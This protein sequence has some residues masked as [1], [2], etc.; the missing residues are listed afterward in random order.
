MMFR[1]GVLLTL[2]STLALAQD[3]PLVSFGVKGGA[4]IKGLFQDGYTSVFRSSSGDVLRN[5]ANA[6]DKVYLVGPSVEVRLPFRLA[7]EFDALY[8]R[9]NG[10]Q[11]NTTVGS[12]GQFTT[13]GTVTAQQT[14]NRWEFPL[15]AKFRIPAGHHV[16]PFVGVG[17]NFSILSQ[18]RYKSA[19]VFSGQPVSQTSFPQD[20]R[21]FGTGVTASGGLSFDFAHVRFT[22]EVRYTWRDRRFFT[23]PTDQNVVQ[24]LIGISFGK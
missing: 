21:D 12:G 22:P 24:A 14:A 18:Q 1:F 6:R 8:S 19:T 7:V 17:P 15:L 9:V 16:H 13:I 11:T 23:V 2:A 4:F 10:E 20:A 5:S 3:E